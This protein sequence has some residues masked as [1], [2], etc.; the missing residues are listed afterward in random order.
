MGLIGALIWVVFWLGWLRRVWRGRR[1]LK[2]DGFHREQKTLEVCLLG[3]IA[4]LVNCA[5]DPTLEGAQ[6]AA[7]LWTMTGLGLLLSSGGGAGML[8][9]TNTDSR[10][11][12]WDALR[13]GSSAKL[14]VLA[15]R[16][17]D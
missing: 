12:F 9:S 11:G 13:R 4:I 14:P 5:F 7:L 10:L 6:V 15:S 8:S 16:Y 1:R 2:A 17:E 3:V